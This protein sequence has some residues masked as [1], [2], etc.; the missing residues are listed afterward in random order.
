MPISKDIFIKKYLKSLEN[1]NAAIFAGAGLSVPSGCVNWK[2]LL[3]EI[4]EELQ[5]KG[6]AIVNKI[7][8]FINQQ[9]A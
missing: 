7:Q 4:A 2:D 9:K 8:G 6:D 1:G 3:R 5:T